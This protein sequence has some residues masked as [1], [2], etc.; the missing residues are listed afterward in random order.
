MSLGVPV[1]AADHG[2]PAEILDSAGLLVAPGDADA[3][4]GAIVGLLEDPELRSRSGTAGRRTVSERFTLQRQQGELLAALEDVAARPA[5]VSWLVPDVV[6]GLGGT[7]RQT[8]TTAGELERRGH[9]VRILTRRRERGLA[10]REV[11]EGLPVERVGV[12]GNDAVAEKASLLFLS[13]RLARRRRGIDVVQVVMYPDFSSE[14]GGGGLE[15]PHG[16]GLGGARRRHRHAE[17]GAWVARRMQRWLR[18]RVGALPASRVDVGARAELGALGFESEIVPVPIDLTRFRPPS[19]RRAR[20][21]PCPVRARED[22]YVVVYTGQLRRLKAVDR[23][24]DAF[25]RFRARDRRARLLVVGGASGTADACVDQL[26]AQIREA[27]IE[28]AVT[29][30]G[31][32]HAVVPY[33]W[34]AEVFVLPSEREGFSNSLA[35]A[36]ACGIACVAPEHPI[37]GEVRGDAGLVSPDN[38][39]QSLLDAFVALADDPST[40]VLLGAAAAERA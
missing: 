39:P 22:D 36:M 40:R 7:T 20:G 38:D 16:D 5:S 33:L 18:R 27:G 28:H 6:A 4:S 9:R 21:R 32:V 8:L 35:E 13:A 25:E 3:L 12:P 10:R 30:T 37:G 26:E 11:V 2:G 14:R 23:L 17:P 31:R 15:S 34:A 29:F 24:I 19:A 1:V